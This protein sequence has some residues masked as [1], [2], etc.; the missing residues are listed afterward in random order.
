MHYS[1]EDRQEANKHITQWQGVSL[2]TKKYK[3]REISKEVYLSV[4]YNAVQI[5][6]FL[7]YYHV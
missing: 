4:S 7:H 3:A 2:A 5:N 1:E 6:I